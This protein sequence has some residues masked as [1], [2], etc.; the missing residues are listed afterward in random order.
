MNL[1]FIFMNRNENYTIWKYLNNE[2]SHP[3]VNRPCD[4]QADNIFFVHINGNENFCLKCFKMVTS[5]LKAIVLLSIFLPK[6][7]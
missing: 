4:N 5:F 6:T 3:S 7:I 2:Y 1:K